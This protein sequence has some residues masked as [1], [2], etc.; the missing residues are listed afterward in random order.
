MSFLPHPVLAV[1]QPI[2]IILIL[3]SPLI[4]EEEVLRAFT[5]TRKAGTAPH[6]IYLSHM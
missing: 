5:G 2:T 3:I 6:T 1:S 4:Q